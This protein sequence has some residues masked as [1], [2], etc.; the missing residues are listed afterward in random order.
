M[1]NPLGDESKLTDG[2]NSASG[3]TRVIANY[4]SAMLRGP[5]KRREPGIHADLSE[6]TLEVGYQ[7]AAAMT[8]GLAV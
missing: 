3:V 7:T 4:P 1:E 2:A 5:A 8:S 6:E